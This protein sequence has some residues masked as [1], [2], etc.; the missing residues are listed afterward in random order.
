MKK[1][2]FLEG[3][4]IATISIIISKVLGLLYVIP[5]Y[6]IIGESGGA[7]YGYAYTIYNLF[8]IISTAGIPFAI[9]KLTSEYNAL[10]LYETKARMYKVAKKFIMIFSI[11]SFIICFVFAPSISKLII[12]NLKGGNTINDVTYVVR[13]VSFALLVIPSLSISRG[14]L[15]GHKYITQPSYS[16]IIE[17]VIRIAVILIGSYLAI[18][19]FHLS[20]TTAV[21]IAVFG[22]TAGGMVAYFY[23]LRAM[24]KEEKKRVVINKIDQV[25]ISN[26]EIVKKIITYSIPFIIIYIANTIYNSVDM[27]LILHTLTKLGFSATDTEA[28]SSVFTTWGVKIEMILSAISTGLIVSLIPNIVGSYVKKDMKDVNNKFN[29]SLKTILLVIVPLSVIISLTSQSVWTMFYG[30]TKYGYYVLQFMIITTIVDCLNM[31]L[32][33]LLQSL[34]RYKIIYISI[35]T[36]VIANACLDIPF[37]YLFHHFGLYPFYGAILATFVG[38]S[39]SVILS[40]LHLKKTMKLDYS[41]SFILLPRILFSVLMMILFT[42]LISNFIPL[43]N[44]SRVIQ[45]PILLFYGILNMGIFILVNLKPFKQL[46]MESAVLQSK[47]KK[48]KMMRDKLIKRKEK[49]WNQIRNHK[50]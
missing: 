31:V 27:I 30:E 37:M 13:M 41:E 34:N 16:Q 4:F 36:G 17:Q 47:I 2:G 15:Q 20:L 29:Q 8:L 11:V 9:S 18:K 26:K 33:S 35:I 6:S 39:L 42:Q 38:F 7:L 46:I 22:A 44:P 32:T 48:L 28:I 3:A 21:G 49:T 40:I 5:F 12:G 14:Y 10:E 25:Y 19:V 1:S 45:I 24:K 50:K 23:L 43:N